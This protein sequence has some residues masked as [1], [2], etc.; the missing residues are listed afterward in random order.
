MHKSGEGGRGRTANKA[1][2]DVT[3]VHVDDNERVQFLAL[4]FQQLRIAHTGHLS[5]VFKKLEDN[6]RKWKW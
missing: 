4:R 3:S 1:V 5:D 6:S 2:D